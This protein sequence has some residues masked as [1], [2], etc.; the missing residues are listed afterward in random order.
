MVKFSGMQNWKG[1]ANNFH[2]ISKQSFYLLQLFV[3]SFQVSS[4]TGSCNLFII[5]CFTGTQSW[6]KF[7]F[8]LCNGGQNLPPP[9]WDRVKVSENLGATA[10]A[11]VAPMDTS[12]LYSI[13]CSVL[14]TREDKLLYFELQKQNWCLNTFFS[15]FERGKGEEIKILSKLATKKHGIIGIQKHA[16]KVRKISC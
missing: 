11:P 3:K 5:L 9:S 10:V 14:F 8:D 16:G 1:L 13:E 6:G 15:H 12:L 4:N 2:M 7:R